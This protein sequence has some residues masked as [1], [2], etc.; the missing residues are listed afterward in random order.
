MAI[1]VQI[2]DALPDGGGQLLRIESRVDHRRD[3][4]LTRSRGG[5]TA[6]P[7]WARIAAIA[8]S[9]RAEVDTDGGDQAGAA[10]VTWGTGSGRPAITAAKP[11]RISVV[12]G[13]GGSGCTEA[14]V[15]ASTTATIAAATSRG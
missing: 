15:A 6:S 8:A 10:V 2:S 14:M 3:C 1:Y 5:L 9:S 4:Q 12:I 13:P 7:R 11:S